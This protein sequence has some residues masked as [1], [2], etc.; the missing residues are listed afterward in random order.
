[1]RPALEVSWSGHDHHT[2]DPRHGR[3]A[4]ATGGAG[5]VGTAITRALQ[6]TGHSRVI[7]DRDGDGA[8]GLPSETSTRAATAAVLEDDRRG[9]VFVHFAAAFDQ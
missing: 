9:D 4:V 1:M 6:G 7:L 2:V 5:A 8:C 3:I